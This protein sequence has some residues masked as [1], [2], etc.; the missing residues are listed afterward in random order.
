MKSNKCIEIPVDRKEGFAVVRGT[1]V[2][3]IVLGEPLVLGTRV[4]IYV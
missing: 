1:I 4:Y 3:Q 2:P